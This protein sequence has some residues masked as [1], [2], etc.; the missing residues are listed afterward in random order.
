M[1]WGHWQLL[2]SADDAQRRALGVPKSEVRAVRRMMEGGALE[3]QAYDPVLF[4]GLAQQW[5][6]ARPIVGSITLARA[7]ETDDEV[8]SWIAAGTPPI[9]C[10][11]GSMP[12]DS[13]SDAVAMITAVCADLGERA[14]ISSGVWDLDGVP[15][16]DHVKIVGSVNHAA[17]FPT[18]R[19]VVHHG[20]SGTTAASL[21]SGVPTVV[22]WVGGDQP[23]WARQVAAL[24]VGQSRR[25]SRMKRD[26]LHA[27]LRSVLTPEYADRAR[28]VAAQMIPAEVSVSTAADLLEKAADTARVG[29]ADGVSGQSL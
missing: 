19:V 21:R 20:G 26:S 7:T 11:F 24:K 4:P 6:P 8:A 13:P 25:F 22:L 28:Q 5:G 3:I 23:V 2:K 10:G 14:L 12:V 29:P 15:Q 16:A 1:E 27:A 17:V 9:Y 18:C